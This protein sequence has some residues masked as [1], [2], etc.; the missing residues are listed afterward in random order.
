MQSSN[1]F[2]IT[3]NRHFLLS[4]SIG[5]EKAFDE[6]FVKYYPK[7][8]QFV[9]HF[10]HDKSVAEDIVQDLFMQLWINRTH[11]LGIKNIDNYL[12]VSARNAA[13]RCLKD[14]FTYNETARIIPES[15][16]IENP[17]VRLCYEELYKL[18]MQEV[19]KMPEQRRKVFLMS[20]V[21]GMSNAE[22]AEKLGVSKRTIEKHISLGI[23][24]LREIFYLFILLTYLN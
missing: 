17:E 7:V 4:L 3:N 2:D 20:R 11:F 12:F 18:L 15:N 19:Q 9:M 21:E 16:D 10:N 5:D 13:L 14:S 23:A 22:I 6:L 1:P 8:L 24:Y